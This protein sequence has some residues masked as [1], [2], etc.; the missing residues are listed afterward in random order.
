[1]PTTVIAEHGVLRVTDFEQSYTV[2]PATGAML[3]EVGE[4][5]TWLGWTENL[6][7]CMLTCEDYPGY[8]EAL[9]DA[10]ARAP[11]GSGSRTSRSPS[12]G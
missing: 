9:V 8:L 3:G 2:D 4:M 1:M 10:G 5:P 6:H 12:A 7:E 11:D